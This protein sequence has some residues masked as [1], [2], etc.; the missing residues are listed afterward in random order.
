M[1][2]RNIISSHILELTE[3]IFKFVVLVYITNLNL[4]F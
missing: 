4:N 1:V 2:T 3:G